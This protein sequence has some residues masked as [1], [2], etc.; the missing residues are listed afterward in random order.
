MPDLAKA[1][2]LSDDFPRLTRPQ[3]GDWL[4]VHH[5]EG[6][7]VAEFVNCDW[8]RPD[9]TRHKIYLQPLGEFVRGHGPPLERLRELASAYFT[10]EVELLPVLEI[11]GPT[12][13][14]RINRLT[15]NRQLLVDDLLARL[16]K[17]LP[18]DAFC[19]L[20]IT[21]Q[22]L[23]PEPEWNFVFGIATLRQRVGVISWAR[24]D[25]A[26]YGEPR[27][28]DF[29]KLLLKRTA[30]VMIHEI[31]HMYGLLHCIY[32]KCIMNG[33]NHLPEG[34]QRP[35]HLCP[36]CLRKLH[37]A[38]GFDITSRYRQLLQVY[39]KCG[40]EAEAQWIKRRLRNLQADN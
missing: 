25:P 15:G 38:V 40:F 31:G 39:Q 12:L 24:Y 18:A 21:D 32:G 26:L 20:G 23:Y 17:R 27:G 14:T 10:L 7:P 16:Q 5:E 2:E 37:Q 11:N 29:R 6:Q 35:P 28:R 13:T 9:A 3:P 1:F 8:N 30:K 33:S 36:V 19:L 22:D 4:A 34:D